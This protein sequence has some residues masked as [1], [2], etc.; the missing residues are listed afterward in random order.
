MGAVL[1]YDGVCGLCHRWVAFVWPRDRRRL[2]RF[3]PLQGGPAR[4]L[5]A[6]HGRDPD[7]LDTVVLVVDHGTPAE[8]LLE[9]SAAALYVLRA[10]GGVWRVVA[11]VVGLLPRRLLDRGY[12][13]L[14]RHRY[15][16]FGRLDACPVPGPELRERFLEG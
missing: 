13:L 8:R 11:A 1:L 5:L 14:A 7:A 3:A 2:F 6:R 10:L 4:A 15:R 9:R 12:D 16:L